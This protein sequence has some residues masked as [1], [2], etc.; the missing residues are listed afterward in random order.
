MCRVKNHDK[1]HLL[2][3][4]TPANLQETFLPIYM[5]TI[6]L[7]SIYFCD[8]HAKAVLFFLMF[9][10]WKLITVIKDTLK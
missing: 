5:I 1:I 7:I 2:I 6:A 9:Y 3:L 8:C 4:S 10:N